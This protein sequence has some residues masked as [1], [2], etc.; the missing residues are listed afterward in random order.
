MRPKRICK[1]FKNIPH[2]GT[3]ASRKDDDQQRRLGCPVGRN[4]KMSR[5]AQY[6]GRSIN[7][8]ILHRGAL[9]GLAAFLFLLMIHINPATS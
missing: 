6:A 9:T 4:S 2:N 1:H 5:E 3:A 7:G 8:D